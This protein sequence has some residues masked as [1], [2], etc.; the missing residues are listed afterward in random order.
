MEQHFEVESLMDFTSDRKRMSILVRDLSDDKFKL[1]IK[2]ADSEIKKRLKPGCQDENIVN[3]IEEFVSEA[4]SEGLR[5]LFFAMKVLDDEEV[6]AFQ[7]ELESIQNSLDRI[8]I[9]TEDLYS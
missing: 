2:G 7:V 9:R 3:A 1:Y 5:T 4:S 8:E 6:H